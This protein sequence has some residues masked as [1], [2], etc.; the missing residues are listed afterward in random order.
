M[1]ADAHVH[2]ALMVYYNVVFALCLKVEKA[3]QDSSLRELCSQQ[4]SV[5]Q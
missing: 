4:V 2:Y 5:H 3:I 1:A